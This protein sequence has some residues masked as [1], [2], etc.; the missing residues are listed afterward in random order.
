MNRIVT[1]AR[2]QALGRRDGLI[3]PLVIL[4]IAFT[5]NV[6]IFAAAADAFDGKVFTGGLLSIYVVVLVF[7]AISVT[8][9]FPFAL[10]MSVTRREFTAAT[11]LFVLVQTCSYSVLLV[12]LQA[13]ED[14]TDGWG[15]RL[16]YFGLGLLQHYGVVTQFAIYAVPMLLMTLTGI[17]LGALYARWKV[18]GIFTATAV[19]IL[20][21]GGAAALLLKYDGF[22][23]VGRWFTHTSAVALFAGWPLPLVALLTVG[24]WLAL[25]RA[26]P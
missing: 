6:V 18:N 8:Q 26:T 17:A 20:L 21:T 23:A 5:V 12:L 22:P 2:L 1:I 4:A 10:G 9:Q 11:G 25:R 16:H 13:I 15:V 14:A 7:G 19:L 3:W 24:S